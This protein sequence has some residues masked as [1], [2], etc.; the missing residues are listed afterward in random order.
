MYNDIQ[1]YKFETVNRNCHFQVCSN[2]LY[3]FPVLK[4]ALRSCNRLNQ[5]KKLNV[6]RGL[7][8]YSNSV[9]KIILSSLILLSG[10]T[11]HA[12][13]I[14]LISQEITEGKINAASADQKKQKTPDEMIVDGEKKLAAINQQIDN[15]G[16]NSEDSNGE[17]SKLGQYSLIIEEDLSL[18]YEILNFLQKGKMSYD[19]AVQ[20][21]EKLSQEIENLN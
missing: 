6:I 13:R 1:M 9:S 12:E 5:Y 7:M 11:L 18:M 16:K 14:D 17:L 20:K 8:N 15:L 19:D 21:M 2:A 10:L 3:L 4:F